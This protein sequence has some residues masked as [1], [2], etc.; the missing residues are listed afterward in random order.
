MGLLLMIDIACLLACMIDDSRRSDEHGES[1]ET[2]EAENLDGD[3][4]NVGI[5][6][7]YPCETEQEGEG[8]LSSSGDE[9]G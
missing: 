2:N 1:N 9:G 8:I 6:S 5:Q 3:T 4:A 7:P